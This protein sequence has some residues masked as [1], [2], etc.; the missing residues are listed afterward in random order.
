MISITKEYL[1]Q[2]FEKEGKT[3]TDI[4]RQL[5]CA[6]TTVYNK[7]KQYNIAVQPTGTGVIEY[8][9][10]SKECH[11][12][13]SHTQDT[14]GYP[15]YSIQHK[16]V[17]MNRFV[18]ALSKGITLESIKGKVVRHTCDNP[19]CIN[20]DHLCIGTTQDNVAD[21]VARNRQPKGETH[22]G[23]TITEKVAYKIKQYLRAGETG[24]WIACKL[25]VSKSIIYHIKYGRSWAW[26]K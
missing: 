15:V 13:I 2:A 6:R 26:L 7:L 10:D 11:I 8:I 21:K 17:R 20:P 16:S 18:Y 22:G 9:T 12:C 1:L 5:G 14:D 3:A 23:H 4:A 24:A 19:T 25:N